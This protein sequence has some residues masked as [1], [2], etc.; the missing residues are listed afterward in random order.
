MLQKYGLLFFFVYI[1]F[2]GVA[3]YLGITIDFD[4]ARCIKVIK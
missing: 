2:R 3:K 4:K 1:L